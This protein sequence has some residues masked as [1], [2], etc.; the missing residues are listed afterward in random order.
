M[1]AEIRVA[2]F[3]NT[4]S[5]PGLQLA[6]LLTGHDDA[7]FLRGPAYEVS[8]HRNPSAVSHGSNRLPTTTT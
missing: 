7:W 4:T 3:D 2:I 8:G 5:A 1:S 6:Y